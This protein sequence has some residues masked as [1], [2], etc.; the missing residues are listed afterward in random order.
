[1]Y[2]LPMEVINHI[3]DYNDIDERRLL[4]IYRKINI[5]KYKF[6]ES[7]IR[8]KILSIGNYYTKYYMKNIHDFHERE[9]YGI[10]NDGIEMFIM[11]SN[12]IVIYNFY[13]FRL[14]THYNTDKS[15]KQYYWD[16]VNYQHVK[17]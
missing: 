14:K 13:L 2:I 12:S 3:I 15:Y 5:G 8:T 11:V 4:G 6:L 1:M 7:I 17:I 10:E 16:N 9:K